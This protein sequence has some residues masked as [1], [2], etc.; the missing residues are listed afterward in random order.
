[1]VNMALVQYQ[2]YASNSNARTD[3]SEGFL[4][5]FAFNVL[6]FALLTIYASKTLLMRYT[7]VLYSHISYFRHAS[8][9]VSDRSYFCQ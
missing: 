2:S 9:E 3:V 1:M 6:P 4:V 5:W 8:A 7:L